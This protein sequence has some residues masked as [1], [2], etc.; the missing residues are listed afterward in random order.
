MASQQTIIQGSRNSELRVGILCIG[1][2][3]AS[4][5]T[6]E[7]LVTQSPGAH[8]VDNV[9]WLVTPREV[10]R[11]L[12]QF[13]HRVCIVDFDEGEESARV[14]RKLREGCETAVTLFAASSDSRPDQIIA[15]MRAGCS[16]Y[17]IKP[18]QSDQLVEALAHVASWTQG[19]LPTTKGRVVTL[20]GAKGGAGVTSL[21]VHLALSLVQRHSKRVLLVDQH[22][23]LGEVTLCLGLGRH[24]YSFYELVHNMDRLDAE[25]LQGFLLKH[26][27]GL[28]VLDA[29]QAMQAFRDTPADAI[30]HTLAF[31]SEN[32]DVVIVDSPPGLSEDTC[33]A[34]RQSE[35]MAIIITPELP[36]IHN[37]IRTMEYLTGLHYPSENIDI[38]LNR[39]SRKNA[40]E[41]REIESS[42]H[43]PITLRIPNNYAQIV[44]AINA[45]MPIDRAHKS[46]LPTAFDSWADR[47]VGEEPST[48]SD[49]GGSRKLF[50]LFGG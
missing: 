49:S 6:L 45:G 12:E 23:S 3:P 26:G 38:V 43:R 27:S 17:L 25:L 20:T 37:A 4:R 7:T 50:G 11:M 28:H 5:D 48:T 9:D 31:L 47:L 29:P 34:I 40:L 13:Q 24:Q 22:P 14:A 21:A 42:L 46:D 10:M 36:A 1:L 8:I 16:E 41:D 30:E 18:F 44:G 35:R 39:Y 2:D 19:K 15:A 33:A 32:Y